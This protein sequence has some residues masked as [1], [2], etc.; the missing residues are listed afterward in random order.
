MSLDVVEVRD[1]DLTIDMRYHR[2]VGHHDN[3]T[4]RSLF[5]LVVLDT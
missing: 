2:N 3:A 1:H 5:A 4:L